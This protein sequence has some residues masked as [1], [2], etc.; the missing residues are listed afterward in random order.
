MWRSTIRFLCI[1]ITSLQEIIWGELEN[2]KRCKTLD[3]FEN[4]RGSFRR[5][6]F[7]K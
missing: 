4:V 1:H 3:E 7:G 6:S 2:Q 5:T